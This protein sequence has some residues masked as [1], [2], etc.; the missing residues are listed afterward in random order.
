MKNKTEISHS[1]ALVK[2]LKT[3]GLF[4]SIFHHL[5]LIGG[6]RI[7]IFKLDTFF[8]QCRMCLGK[9]KGLLGRHT[10]FLCRDFRLDRAREIFFFR[11]NNESYSFFSPTVTTMIAPES[12]YFLVRFNFF[13]CDRLIF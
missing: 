5:L 4:R 2:I 8:L 6:P 7:L 9:K 11:K 1:V 12:N 13:H 10:F 3:D